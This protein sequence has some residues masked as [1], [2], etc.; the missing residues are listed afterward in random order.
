[1]ER[2][3]QRV[4]EYANTLS[5]VRTKED[6]YYHDW[7]DGVGDDD[8][9]MIEVVV[10]YPLLSVPPHLDFRQRPLTIPLAIFYDRRTTVYYGQ[11]LVLPDQYQISCRIEYPS[12]GSVCDIWQSAY[13]HSGYICPP[14]LAYYWGNRV[15]SLPQFEFAHYL[16]LLPQTTDCPLIYPYTVD[17]IRHACNEWQ[18]SKQ[19]LHEILQDAIITDVRD[20]IFN[21]I[22]VLQL[23]NFSTP[24]PFKPDKTHIRFYSH[25]G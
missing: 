15:L 7:L 18:K 5:L 2:L 9:G 3:K 14:S 12:F 20:I 8:K 10:E 22:F 6:A 19:K 25:Y 4:E 17:M 24:I 21:Y 23:T 11:W 16:K 13:Q 1:M